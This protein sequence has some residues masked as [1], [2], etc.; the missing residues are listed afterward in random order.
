MAEEDKV[1]KQGEQKSKKPLL[2]GQFI[3]AINRD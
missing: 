2:N 3:C 1:S